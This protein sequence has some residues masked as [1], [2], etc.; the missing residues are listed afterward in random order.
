MIFKVSIISYI[1]LCF[2]FGIIASAYMRK[3]SNILDKENIAISYMELYFSYDMF[4]AL[5]QNCKDENTKK[6]YVKLYNYAV[7]TRN[8]SFGLIISFIVILP[9]LNI[10]L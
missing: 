9:I 1:I 3:I 10:L 8:I 7:I 6:R 4:K 5:I 2:I